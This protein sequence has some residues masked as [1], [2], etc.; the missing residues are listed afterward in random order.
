MI[1]ARVYSL[2]NALQQVITPLLEKTS[3]T[4]DLNSKV[5]GITDPHNHTHR[6]I[7]VELGRLMQDIRVLGSASEYRSQG[8]S[9]SFSYSKNQPLEKISYSNGTE[10]N[11]SYDNFNRVLSIVNQKSDGSVINSFS[12]QCHWFRLKTLR[13][14][15]FE[16]FSTY[17]VASAFFN[18]SW[19]SPS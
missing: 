1:T 19:L 12:Y 17:R 2:D 6:K 18:C 5:N 9:A 15:A 14:T 13:A 8:E 11:Y 4:Y 7:H 16:G 3:Y 10:V